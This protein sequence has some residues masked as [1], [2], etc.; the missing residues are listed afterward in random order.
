MLGRKLLAACSPPGNIALVRQL[1]EDRADVNF[2]GVQGHTITL[3]TAAS[4]V[5]ARDGV[6]TIRVVRAGREPA[7]LEARRK[8][9]GEV[10]LLAT[11][12][13]PRDHYRAAWPG[14]E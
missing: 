11:S 4:V 8:A 13:P 10:Q 3:N 1:V 6:R 14:R 5:V 12:R 7:D 9:Q 2:G